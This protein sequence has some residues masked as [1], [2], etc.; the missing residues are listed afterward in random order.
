MGKM[1]LLGGGSLFLTKVLAFVFPFAC[2]IL[3]VN[4]LEHS[5]HLDLVLRD[6]REVFFFYNI[7]LLI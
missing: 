4:H 2:I 1:N 7:F 6:K 3:T 5:G